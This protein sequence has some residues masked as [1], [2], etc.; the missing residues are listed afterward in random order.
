MRRLTWTAF[1][2]LFVAGLLGP[3]GS[4]AEDGKIIAV[5]L[6]V[7]NEVRQRP[8]DDVDWEPAR[9]GQPLTSGHELRTGE[10]SF[11]ALIFQDDQ[12]L[13]KITSN[14]EVTL[15]SHEVGGG[16]FSKK[17]WVGV[18][19]LWAQVTKRND[20]TFE[21][22]TPTSVASVKGSS[23]YDMVDLS[24]WTTLFVQSGHFE[25]SNPFGRVIVPPGYRGFSNGTDPPDTTKTGAGEAPSF[26][27][28]GGTE[29]FDQGR[30][31]DDVGELRLGMQDENGTERTLVIRYNDTQ[32]E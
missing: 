20:A 24:G 29:G 15:S 18:G 31:G 1:I 17:V 2:L 10:D 11:C 21:I 16:K 6:K 13:L 12:S 19:G 22:E 14:T 7:K 30:G 26:G 5:V 25:F 4:V 28:N 27:E 23:C 32:E 9:R 3:A 8:D